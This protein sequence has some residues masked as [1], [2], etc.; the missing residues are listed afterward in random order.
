MAR[1]MVS[2]AKQPRISN[3]TEKKLRPAVVISSSAHHRARQEVV[4]AAIASN[5]SRPLFGDQLIGDW[6]GAGFAISLCGGRSH[7]DHQ[8]NDYRTEAWLLGKG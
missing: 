4:V 2:S 8:T 5:V 6:K 1:P 3:E 7:P